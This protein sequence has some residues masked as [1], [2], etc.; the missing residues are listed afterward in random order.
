MISS[1]ASKI[2]RFEALYRRCYQRLFF[3]ALSYV[4][5]NYIAE[6]IVNTAFAKAWEKFSDI[7][8][9]STDKYLLVIVRNGCI[10][11]FRK[12]KHQSSI[13]EIPSLSIF[14]E[15]SNYQEYEEKISAIENAI[16]Q[17]SPV[18]R[19]V[20]YQCYYERKTYKQVAEEQSLTERSVK[21]YIMKALKYIRENLHPLSI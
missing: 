17:L 6:E 7:Q 2:K 1:Q 21:R 8:E 12:R 14:H 13:E 16:K 15:E 18:T 3:H 20:L 5:D 10:D 4:G 19:R 11:F 9:E